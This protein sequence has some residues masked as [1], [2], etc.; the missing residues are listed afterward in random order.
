VMHFVNADRVI[1]RPLAVVQAVAERESSF[2]KCG[3]Y[4]HRSSSIFSA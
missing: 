4:G 1:A 3:S 2:V